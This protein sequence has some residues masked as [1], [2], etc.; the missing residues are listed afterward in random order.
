MVSV[1]DALASGLL[2]GINPLYALYAVMLATPVG[3]IFAGSV[4]MSVQTTS[5]MSLVVASIPEVTGYAAN[6]RALFTLTLLTGILTLIAGFARLGRL[7]RFVSNSVMVGFMNGVAVLIILGQLPNFSGYTSEFSNRLVRAVD[8]LFNLGSVHLPT[9]TVGLGSVILILVLERTRL[10][11]LGMVVALIP[12][13]TPAAAF[14]MALGGHGCGHRA[15]HGRSAAARAAGFL[16]DPS[17]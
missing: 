8:L 10:R 2:A 13:V 11:Q 15:D 16:S 6:G 14:R 17:P 9:I 7:M 5:A 12:R 1:P 4:F 3:A